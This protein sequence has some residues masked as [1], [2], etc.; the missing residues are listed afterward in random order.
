MK[1]IVYFCFFI[2]IFCF[3]DSC[4]ISSS[5]EKEG[6]MFQDI[7]LRKYHFHNVDNLEQFNDSIG[8]TID[9]VKYK[10]SKPLGNHQYAYDMKFTDS[11]LHLWNNVSVKNI[12]KTDPEFLIDGNYHKYQI[13]NVGDNKRT[14]FLRILN[15]FYSSLYNFEKGFYVVEVF[16]SSVNP[17]YDAFYLIIPHDNRKATS[18]H[19]RFGTWENSELMV[20]LKNINDIDYVDFYSYFTKLKDQ[21][22]RDLLISGASEFTVSYF[23][24]DVIESFVSIQY[25]NFDIIQKIENLLNKVY[26]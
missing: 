13:L 19:F 9:T 4:K 1:R 6:V 2:V 18:Y 12:I 21:D 23:R 11:I 3:V 24:N 5:I 22:K 15:C 25:G 8:Y 10:L 16:N 14:E 7:Y 17:H 20:Y 26:F